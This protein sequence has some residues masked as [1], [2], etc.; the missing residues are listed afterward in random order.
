MKFIQIKIQG[1]KKYF[2]DLSP[3]KKI[4]D[5]DT[6]L[7]KNRKNTKKITIPNALN[8]KNSDFNCAIRGSNPG[9]PD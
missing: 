8:I 4:A 7:M 3:D 2:N 5:N 6:D 9:H 1:R